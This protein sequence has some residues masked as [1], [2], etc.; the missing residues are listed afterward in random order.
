M[1]EQNVIQWGQKMKLTQKVW[2]SPT[3]FLA[4][5]KPHERS[6]TAPLVAIGVTIKASESLKMKYGWTI[7]LLICLIYP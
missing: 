7:T 1:S 6:P 5:N 2:E 3:V 4:L